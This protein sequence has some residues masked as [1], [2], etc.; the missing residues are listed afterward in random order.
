[1][2]SILIILKRGQRSSRL[3]FTG[4][5][6][7]RSMACSHLGGQNTKGYRHA[8]VPACNASA[9]P[10]WRRLPHIQ[11]AVPRES[12]FPAQPRRHIYRRFA[13]ASVASGTGGRRTWPL[14]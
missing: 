8:A 6:P 11:R 10:R 5:V 1:M 3:Y 13:S 9:V 14:R 7:A 4:F 2:A 12:R